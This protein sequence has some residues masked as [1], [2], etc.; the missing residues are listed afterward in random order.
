MPP[1]FLYDI[2]S[3]IRNKLQIIKFKYQNSNKSQITNT[4]LVIIISEHVTVGKLFSNNFRQTQRN[5]R[6]RT[7]SLRNSAFFAHSAFKNNFVFD[8]I[9]IAL[10]A[11]PAL[12]F[13]FEAGKCAGFDELNREAQVEGCAQGFFDFC[14]EI[15]WRSTF[16]FG[17]D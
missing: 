9:K 14:G 5:F 16:W 13:H 7:I 11:D 12:G 17:F 2:K 15:F 8:K 1:L 4:K 3:E 6:S 10:I